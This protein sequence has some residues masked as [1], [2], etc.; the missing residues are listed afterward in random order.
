LFREALARGMLRLVRFVGAR[1]VDARAVEQRAIRTVLT[2]RR[3]A[4]R[5]IG[6]AELRT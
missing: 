1:S 2:S 6:R 4:Q 3:I 5:S